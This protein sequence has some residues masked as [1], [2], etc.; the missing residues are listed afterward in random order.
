MEVAGR[1]A[2]KSA[3]TNTVPSGAFAGECHVCLVFAFMLIGQV[4]Y[5][6]NSTRSRYGYVLTDTEF[7]AIRRISNEFGAIEVAQSVY[8]NTTGS[9]ED[10]TLAFAL[11]SL[12]MVAKLDAPVE[13]V[14]TRP[15]SWRVTRSSHLRLPPD[16]EDD[17]ASDNASE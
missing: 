8:W 1:V 4:F 5:Y 10:M 11:W 6:M 12:H 7:V 16:E 13:S 15:P 9:E 17:D 3:Q 2:H 14:V